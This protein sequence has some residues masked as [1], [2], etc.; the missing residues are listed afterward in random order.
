L[1]FSKVFSSSPAGDSTIAASKSF[2]PTRARADP[3]LRRP[4]GHLNSTAM[5]RSKPH[6]KFAVCAALVAITWV[7]FGQTLGHQFV[8]YD[9]LLYVVENQHIRAGLSWHGILWALTQVHSQNWHRSH[10]CRTCWTA[11]SSGFSL[12]GIILS[13]CCCTAPGLFCCFLRFSK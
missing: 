13:M 2:N 4:R 8:N 6:L 11:S 7:I 1:R 5:V 3:P 10:R 9:D 12:D